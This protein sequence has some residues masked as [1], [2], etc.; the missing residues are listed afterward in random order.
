MLKECIEKHLTD[1][2]SAILSAARLAHDDNY[3]DFVFQASCAFLL[4]LKTLAHIKVED[5]NGVDFY[6]AGVIG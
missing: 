4:P 2:S 3:G 5:A 6:Q 1:T